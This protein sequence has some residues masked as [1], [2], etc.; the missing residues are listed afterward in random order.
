MINIPGEEKRV[1]REDSFT[2]QDEIELIAI[3]NATEI[4]PDK[5]PQTVSF[6]KQAELDF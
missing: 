2:V 5:F 1:A 3:E 4:L 6:A